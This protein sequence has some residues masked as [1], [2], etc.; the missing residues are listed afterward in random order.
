MKKIMKEKG[1]PINE[2]PGAYVNIKQVKGNK[3]SRPKEEYQDYVTDFIQKKSNG[4]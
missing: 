2:D 3:N 4:T 1:L